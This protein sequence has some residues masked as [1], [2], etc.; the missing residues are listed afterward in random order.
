MNECFLCVKRTSNVEY[1]FIINRKEKAIAIFHA[2]L[3]NNA[4]IILYAYDELAD[5]LYQ[6]EPT[7]IFIRGELRENIK[8]EILEMYCM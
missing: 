7:Q 2:I 8:I 4:K 6:K 1:K 5:F 3:P